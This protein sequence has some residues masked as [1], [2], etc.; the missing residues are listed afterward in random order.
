MNWK[1]KKYNKFG[2]VKVQQDGQK[3]DSKL[4]LYCYNQMQ[5]TDIPFE[6]QVKINLLPKYRD[7]DNKGIRET[8]LI[9]D[10]VLSLGEITLYVDTKGFF[11]KDA[12]LK[13]KML[14]HKI[15]LEGNKARVIFLKNKKEVDSFV[16]TMNNDRWT[17]D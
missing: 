10:F 12:M 3:F 6:F 4:E 13:Y 11:T 2:A 1:K 9:V 16:N 14:K 5:I 8:N 17:R 15:Y 7:I